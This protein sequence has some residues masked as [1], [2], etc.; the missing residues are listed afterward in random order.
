MSA[1]Q[2]LTSVALPLA[3][4]HN[5]FGTSGIGTV[6]S[7]MVLVG[8]IEMIV[9]GGFADRGYLRV[10]L[11]FF[12]LTSVLC[13]APFILRASS[14]WLAVAAVIGGYGG[15]QG[16]TS[17]GTGPYQPAEYAWIGR[18]YSDLDRNRLVGI[19]SAVSVGGVVLGS[20]F[21]IAAAPLARTLHFG[22]GAA[23]QAR[24]LILMVGVLA[25][26]PT[27]IGFFVKEP[28]H[29]RPERSERRDFAQQVTAWR[30]LFIPEH[31]RSV[32]M[33]LSIVGGLNGVA[34]GCF[35]Q[36]VTVWLILHFHASAATIGIINLAVAGAAV[37]GDL[38]CA[39]FAK[40][41]GLIRSVII[42]RAVQSILVIVVA[43]SPN[44]MFAEIFLLIR[45]VAQRLNLPLR[46]SYSIARA[47]QD[48][49]GRVAALTSISNQGTM[50]A[51][52]EASG[53]L[54]SRF[55]YV[56]PFCVSGV[57][58]LVSALVFYAYFA[59]QPPPEERIVEIGIPGSTNLVVTPATI[60][61]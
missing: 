56:M 16:A 33:R 37:V 53:V 10:F 8:L 32:L 1:A 13:A 5:G 35:G 40:K 34:V 7:V 4:I 21:A 20:L 52:S 9:V 47:A 12:P 14:V 36:F 58:Q 41:L 22:V 6:L 3:L 57:I 17:G 51:S 48:E 23:N 46:D 29:L 31:S 45:Q 27:V 55:G 11:V 15:G 61:G 28:P 42:T 39:R 54:I 43:L 44:L 60:G 2:A 50:A 49:K 25:V 38:C 30:T 19:F 24:V 18:N 26:V 59:R